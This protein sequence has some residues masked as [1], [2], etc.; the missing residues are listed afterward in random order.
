MQKRPSHLNFPMHLTFAGA[1]LVMLGLG[2]STFTQAQTTPDPSDQT[3]PLDPAE[4]LKESGDAA[5][6]PIAPELSAVVKKLIDDPLNRPADKRVLQIFHGQWSEVENPSPQERAA[7]ALARYDL[8]NAVFE[9]PEV[10]ATLRASAMLERGEPARARALLQDDQSFEAQWITAQAMVLQGEYDA[11]AALLEQLIGQSSQVR[12]STR[13]AAA[14]ATLTGQAIIALAELRG[15]KASDYRSAL[16]KFAQAR[17]DMDRFYYPAL[18]QEAALLASRDNP[19]DAQSAA[20]EA[21]VL[22]PNDGRLWYTLGHMAADHFNFDMTTQILTQLRSINAHH[23]LADRLE[24][25]ARLVQRDPATSLAV[26]EPALARYPHD[27]HLLA[28][29]V[30][31]QAAIFDQPAFENAMARFDALFPQS[32]LALLTTGRVLSM[33]R[34]YAR[35]EAMLRKVIERRPNLPRAWTELGLLLMQSGD[36]PAALA[37]LQRGST[38]DPFDVRAANQL[39]LVQELLGYRV[40]ETDHFLI[41]YHQGVDEVLAR[42]MPFELEGM[43]DELTSIFQHRP[44]NKTII[45]ILPDLKRFAV[46]IT[47]MPD[48]WTI[49]ASTGDIIAITPPRDGKGQHGAFD[50]LR[51]I[52]HEFVHTITLDQTGNRIPHWFTEGAAVWQEPGDRDF[53][54]SRLLAEALH[55]GQLFT[56]DQINWGFIRPKRQ[57]DRPLAYAQAHWMIQYIVASS[58][59]QAVVDMLR[60]FQKGWTDRQA[61]EKVTGVEGSVFMQGFSAWAQKQVDLWGLGQSTY[62]KRAQTLLQEP[63]KLQAGVLTELL[64]QYPNDPELLLLAAKRAMM[65]FDLNEARQAVLRYATARPVDPWSHRMLVELAFKKKQPLEARGAL[66][67]LDQQEQ[68]SGTWAVQLSQITREAGDLNAAYE[69]MRRAIHREPYN[70]TYREQTAA[71][72][73]QM[74]DMEAALY[75]LKALPMLEPDRVVHHI[76]L[77]AIYKKIGMA[78]EA[79]AAALRARELNPHAPVD[80]FLKKE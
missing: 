9:D 58:G 30:A 38:L 28:L 22:N 21:A 35:S 27:P 3:Q 52:R 54:T 44:A 25:Y 57:I 5:A 53:D 36:E 19:N 75:Q 80:A 37:A 66:A 15:G 46:R 43:Y 76:R 50:W 13:Q 39:K 79:N 73:L 20:N 49:G 29:D 65:G 48:I 55:G 40:I 31:A 70:A 68:N 33:N 23:L 10:P 32:E 42:D 34:Q 12:A 61:I 72:A 78:D 77:A 11:A 1:L 47:G 51:V 71:I 62:D 74:G 8:N 24:A 18:V 2:I 45:E 41:R 67:Q 17:K 7:I 16:E 64:N 14:A 59:Q 63:G 4:A 26:L 60:L 69:S 56:L 6:K